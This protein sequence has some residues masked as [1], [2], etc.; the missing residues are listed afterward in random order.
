L[1]T[2]TNSFKDIYLKNDIVINGH[3]MSANTATIADDAVGSFTPPMNGGFLLINLGPLSAFP[4]GSSFVGMI[5][6][7]VGSSLAIAKVT[8]GTGS[9]LNVTTSDVDGTTGADNK[10]TVAVQ[11]GVV[12]VENRSGASHA[13][14]LTFL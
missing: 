7:D 5:H 12:K 11:S 13:F 10:V 3:K 14:H 9:N 4:G 1:G 6:F 8:T 2:S